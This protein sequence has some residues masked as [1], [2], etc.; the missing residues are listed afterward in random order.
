M[1]SPVA[2][3][4]EEAEQKE[5]E[6]FADSRHQR[7]QFGEVKS[8]KCRDLVVNHETMLSTKVQYIPLMNKSNSLSEKNIGSVIGDSVAESTIS[9]EPMETMKGVLMVSP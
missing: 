9:S 6:G 1:Q 4:A 3:A 5:T 7:A 2:E 8:A